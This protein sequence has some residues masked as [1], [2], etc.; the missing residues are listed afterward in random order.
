MNGRTDRSQGQWIA[1]GLAIVALVA[2][3]AV[4][5][6]VRTQDSF[7][8]GAGPA[9][10]VA[11]RQAVAFAAC[12]RDDGEPG[13]PTPPPGDGITVPLPGSGT[14][15]RAVAACRPLAPS[16]RE[17]TNVSITLLPRL[18]PGD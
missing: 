18:P 13:V 5:F 9:G 11:Y 1:G 12:M 17:D 4:T 2:L 6:R 8:T 15:A 7:A 16:G 14:E 10:S 3:L